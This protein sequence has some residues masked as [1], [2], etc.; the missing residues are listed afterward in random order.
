MELSNREIA[1]QKR[2]NAKKVSHPTYKRFGKYEGTF[3]ERMQK[4]KTHDAW[5]E[6]GIVEREKFYEE[7]GRQWQVFVFYNTIT[8]VDKKPWIERY[9]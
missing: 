3:E 4:V 6:E 9:K 7:H 1:W 2:K 5:S 8:S